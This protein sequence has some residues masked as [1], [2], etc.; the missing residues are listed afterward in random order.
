M[1]NKVILMGRLTKDPEL[2]RT[3]SGIN[4]A[5]FTLAVERSYAK[6]GEERE[7]DFIN[8]TAF[9]GTADFVCKYFSKGQLVAVSGRLHVRYWEDA[10]TNKTRSATDVIA[11]EVFFAEG[12]KDGQTRQTAPVEQGEPLTGF[13]SSDEDLP[14]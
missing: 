1:L 10:N 13:T 12:K 11:E 7:A 6:Q 5:S 14:F 3:E 4:V 8:I 9:R 2:R